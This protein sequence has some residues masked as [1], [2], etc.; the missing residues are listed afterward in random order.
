MNISKCALQW[1]HV[2]CRLSDGASASSRSQA[3]HLKCIIGVMKPLVVILLLAMSLQ[4]Q[5]IADAA[6]KE[7]E[8]RAGLKP[9]VVLTG[10][11]QAAPDAK[12]AGSDATSRD[13]PKPQV[14]PRPDPAKIWNDQLDQVRTKI[15]TLQDQE[16][17]L[18]LKQN[19]LNNQVYATV[20]EQTTKDQAQ[21]QL[22]QVQQ[23][24][25]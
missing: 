20:V 2:T 10:N 15:R 22:G 11:G 13:L 14:P 16:T 9:A 23:Q 7:R 25:A 4:A 19:E 6:R 3:R 8:R 18:L 17:A 21:A 12:P 24:L 1:L 5:S